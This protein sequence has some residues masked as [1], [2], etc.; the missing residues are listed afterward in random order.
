[1]TFPRHLMGAVA[2]QFMSEATLFLVMSRCASPKPEQDSAR[3]GALI[4]LR[5][6]AVQ[7]RGPRRAPADLRSRRMTCQVAKE[8]TSRRCAGSVLAS[9]NAASRC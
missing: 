3:A 8:R 6:R 2:A 9:S 7:I 4:E 5:A 1:M